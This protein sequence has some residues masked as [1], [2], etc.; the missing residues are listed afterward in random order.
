MIFT[1]AGVHEEPLKYVKRHGPLWLPLLPLPFWNFSFF[2]AYSVPSIIS[3]TA[4]TEFNEPGHRDRRCTWH[5]WSF[6]NFVLCGIQHP[7]KN[8]SK[9]SIISKFISK[10]ILYLKYIN[11]TNF[12]SWELK[13]KYK[14]LKNRWLFNYKKLKKCG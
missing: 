4:F 8:F 12:L 10:F 9:I 1:R 3:S 14:I 2:L 13:E 6:A 7:R 5:T 11:V